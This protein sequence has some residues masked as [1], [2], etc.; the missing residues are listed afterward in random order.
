M[1]ARAAKSHPREVAP[2]ESEIPPPDL[3]T[4]VQDDHHQALRLW[5]R[6]LSTTNMIE[7]ELRSRLR[8]EFDCTMPRFDL[9]A[10]LERVPDGLTMSEVSRRVMVTNAAITGLTDRLV[11]EGY[12][13]RSES[14]TDRR[15]SF[16][17]LTPKGREHF[18]AMARRHEAWVVEMM[19]GMPDEKKNILRQL[20]GDLKAALPRR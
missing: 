10:Q 1:S 11:E 18:L 15:T 17:R 2:A 12:V 5:L 9:M 3:E 16:I 7:T 20:L 19:A 6:L 4:R 14:K 13:E 8:S